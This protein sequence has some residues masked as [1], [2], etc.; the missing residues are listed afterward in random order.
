MSIQNNLTD[1]KIQMCLAQIATD[2][3]TRLYFSRPHIKRKNE[4]GYARLVNSFRV[5]RGVVANE[6]CEQTPQVHKGSAGPIVE[7]L[8]GSIL[9]TEPKFYG[10]LHLVIKYYCNA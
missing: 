4:F 9:R 8:V 7:K 1:I 6:C 3:V 2:R 10:S 5:A